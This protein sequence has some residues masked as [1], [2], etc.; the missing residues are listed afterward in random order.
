MNSKGIKGMSILKKFKNLFASI[1]PE[2]R[3]VAE[4][5]Q[6]KHQVKLKKLMVETTK[7]CNLRCIQC[8]SIE[9]NNF[10]NY[11]AEDL[12]LIAFENLLPIMN[13]H[14][15]MVWLNGHGETLLHKDFFEM[16]GKTREAC[17][18]VQFQTNGMLLTPEKVYKI[19]SSGVECVVFSIDGA[20]KETF[21]SIRRGAHFDVLLRNIKEMNECKKKLGTEYPKLLFQFVAMRQNIHELPELVKLA[22]ELKVVTVSVAQLV[23]YNLTKGQSL[24][25]DPQMAKWASLATAEAEKRGINLIL[26]ASNEELAQPEDKRDDTT[27]PAV[28]VGGERKRKACREPWE[29]S[30]V[31]YNGEVHPCCVINES[32]GDLSKETFNEIWH[33]QKYEKLRERLLTTNPPEVCLSCTLYGWEPIPPHEGS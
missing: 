4:P 25:D 3:R 13:E 11:N 18:A 23:E 9:E 14:K 1:M 30:F 20:S 33:G 31:Q 12:P 26:P 22:S 19:V 2:A 21:E 15:P 6:Q 24:S 28:S 8:A 5:V 27:V 10:G 16:L 7:R 29:T 32:Y 17:C